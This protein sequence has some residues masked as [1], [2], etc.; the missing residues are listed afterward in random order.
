MW[1][2]GTLPM[3][4]FFDIGILRDLDEVCCQ[5]DG[6]PEGLDMVEDL[7]GILFSRLVRSTGM[8]FAIRQSPDSPPV[9]WGDD[10]MVDVP[11]HRIQDV[12][13]DHCR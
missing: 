9:E 11:N 6:F 5:C 10:E 8:V 1:L 13:H 4:S 7:F 12:A 3:G 2:A